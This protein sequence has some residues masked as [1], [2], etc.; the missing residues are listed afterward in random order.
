MATTEINARIRAYS[1][2]VWPVFAV[3]QVSGSFTSPSYLLN[4]DK[5]MSHIP[6]FNK[7]YNLRY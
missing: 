4:A 7:L 1:T 3:R 5:A 2:R 6:I